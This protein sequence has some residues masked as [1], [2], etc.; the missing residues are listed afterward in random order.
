MRT[1]WCVCGRFIYGGLLLVAFC[2]CGAEQQHEQQIAGKSLSQWLKQLD[3]RD[4]QARDEAIANIVS[5]G[6]DA[7]PQVVKALRHHDKDVRCGAAHALLKMDATAVGDVVAVIESSTPDIQATAAIGMVRA[8][9]SLPSAIATLR[10]TLHDP[11]PTVS[12]ASRKAFSDLTPESK[13]AVPALLEML[14][15][16]DAEDRQCAVFAFVRIGPGAAAAVP[17]L[18]DALQQGDAT[19]REGAAQALGAIGEAA[20][21][22]LPLLE[23]AAQDK[24]PNVRFRAA[25]AVRLLRS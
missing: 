6:D 2:G 25:Q 12:H 5:L 18:T 24:D 14:Q 17:A 7:K 10:K 22:A 19:L 16:A 8:N 1:G 13:E 9:V 3:T 21:H 23:T 4:F 11:D 20:K 15:S